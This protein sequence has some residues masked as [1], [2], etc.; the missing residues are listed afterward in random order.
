LPIPL[1]KHE[2]KL[3]QK[4]AE[5]ENGERKGLLG[6]RGQS[7]AYDKTNHPGH[8]ENP[9]HRCPEPEPEINLASF[10]CNRETY[11]PVSQF[12]AVFKNKTW[13]SHWK[14]DAFD[15][16][17]DLSD[18]PGFQFITTNDGK[19]TF[20]R[21]GIKYCSKNLSIGN[22]IYD[23]L[24]YVI[25]KHKWGDS[26]Y[27]VIDPADPADPE[28]DNYEGHD[29]HFKTYKAKFEI[30]CTANLK[31]QL[32]DVSDLGGNLNYYDEEA[33]LKSVINRCELELSLHS[34]R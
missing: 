27:L 26:W 34:S 19:I 31:V 12:D 22:I 4:V 3:A 15:E 8:N 1:E 17:F 14:G 23:Q 5:M 24:P 20:R 11:V 32:E 10:E 29:G 30:N 2:R 7:P 16:S 28:D 6:K 25:Y 18:F 21:I 33:I 13:S 9:D